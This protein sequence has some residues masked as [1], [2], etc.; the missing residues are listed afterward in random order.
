MVSL[1][2]WSIPID[3]QSWSSDFLR[4]GIWF[5]LET[6]RIDNWSVNDDVNDSNERNQSFSLQ[7]IQYDLV[8][9]HYLFF[10]LL[11]NLERNRSSKN[12]VQFCT[13]EIT[14]FFTFCSVLFFSLVLWF[15]Q[16]SVSYSF[17][18]FWFGVQI[19]V[20]I[21]AYWFVQ[22]LRF[23]AIVKRWM[24]R[25]MS[26]RMATIRLVFFMFDLAG[27]YFSIYI[28]FICSMIAVI[29]SQWFV[30]FVF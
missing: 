2:K 15:Y 8:W 7:N 20:I 18:H 26:Q 16:V 29:A 11:V 19:I 30:G 14:S 13:E 24:V 3:S 23:S 5:L 27:R 25:T 21:M 17:C 1:K 28:S 9:L 4:V 6:S 22:F 12:N 10:S